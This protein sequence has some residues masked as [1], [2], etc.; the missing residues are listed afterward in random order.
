M[1]SARSLHAA[2]SRPRRTPRRDGDLAPLRLLEIDQDLAA[3]IPSDQLP[4]ARGASLVRVLALGARQ[5]RP[6]PLPAA[7]GPGRLGM[8]LVSGL[9]LRRLAVGGRSSSE[10]LVPGDMFRPWPEDGRYEPLPLQSDWLVL[11]PATV[12]LLDGDFAQRMSRWPQ[13]V[14]ALVARM[15]ER[16]RQ[17]AVLHALS[18]LARA[19]T[20]LLLTFWVLAERSG[21]VRPDGVL[22]RLPL[23]HSALATIVGLRRPTVTLG[24]QRLAEAG[25]LERVA[26]DEWLLSPDAL[27]VIEAAER[28]DAVAPAGLRS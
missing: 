22:L 7:G 23:T 5:G 16:G 11:A 4:L 9:L 6:S 28:P 19:E 18:H 1:S 3:G 8:Y 24:L 13:V 2:P 21:R 25:L 15:S 10:L 26:R 20:R 27:A 17:Q 12:A 14:G